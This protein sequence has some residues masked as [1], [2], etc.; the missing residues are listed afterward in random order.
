MSFSRY[1]SHRLIALLVM[2][3]VVG[4]GGQSAP[5]P[6]VKHAAHLQK[7]HARHLISQTESTPALQKQMHAKLRQANG[8]NGLT[9]SMQANGRVVDVF[10]EWIVESAGSSTPV[11]TRITYVVYSFMSETVLATGKVDPQ[12]S[13]NTEV[14][15][16]TGD[17][18]CPIVT[19][20]IF[21]TSAT[22][23]RTLNYDRTQGIAKLDFLV[24]TVD[25]S[26]GEI[27]FVD[28]KPTNAICS[29]NDVE[30][31]YGAG[32]YNPVLK[33]A[34]GTPFTRLKMVDVNE[35]TGVGGNYR[36]YPGVKYMFGWG[37]Q[38]C[39][40][41]L[42]D[43][44]TGNCVRGP[45]THAGLVGAKLTD[46][47][48][49]SG[50]I[51][52]G[53]IDPADTPY[54]SNFSILDFD[55]VISINAG[56]DPVNG[57]SFQYAVS[58][59]SGASNI[60][61][62][63]ILTS[64]GG[65]NPLGQQGYFDKSRWVS[66]GPAAN[67][68]PLGLLDSRSVVLMP[69]SGSVG[70]TYNFMQPML[71]WT[72]SLLL[73]D[74]YINSPG[75]LCR[76]PSGGGGCTALGES[77]MQVGFPPVG[78]VPGANYFAA[79]YSG[80]TLFAPLKSFLSTGE[81][82]E[83]QRKYIFYAD[84]RELHPGKMGQP[85][86]AMFRPR[87]L[88]DTAS[89]PLAM[90]LPG[91]LVGDFVVPINS[92]QPQPTV[93]VGQMEF[94]AAKDYLGD[95][96]AYQIIRFDDTGSV[97]PSDTSG[98]Q[99]VAGGVMFCTSKL[100]PPGSPVAISGA[101][102][103]VPRPNAVGAEGFSIASALDI[104]PSATYQASPSKVGYTISPSG[105]VYL[106]YIAQSGAIATINATD[107]SQKWSAGNSAWDVLSTGRLAACLQ[108]LKAQPSPPS[109]NLGFWSR[110]GA[111]F[112]DV[113]FYTIVDAA[114]EAV[115]GPFGP[116]LAD[117]V[118]GMG[119]SYLEDQANATGDQSYLQIYGGSVLTTTCKVD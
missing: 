83:Q 89:P 17:T 46:G 79:P 65:E 81:A 45:T 34:T 25:G 94:F 61:G 110:L 62:T 113:V 72:P 9:S 64:N 69:S 47:V 14:W 57:A 90:T 103:V 26:L 11:E 104:L 24:G 54:T 51:L 108:T 84:T 20:L 76:Y 12:G 35:L 48:A 58:M 18:W 116:V 40:A 75:Y 82:Q 36:V 67:T 88:T 7:L 101:A 37:P 44:Q 115:M 63:K 56:G 33:S 49:A 41:S 117:M 87:L 13:V 30:P 8:L 93:T 32:F 107:P 39:P 55:A 68:P 74:L 52:A 78:I 118:L 4:C 102:C 109:K 5:S 59:A 10:D 100:A 71:L 70:M 42:V 28:K 27:A 43:G 29:S 6:A 86:A 15:R 38:A 99:L 23:R 77:F 50:S 1:V 105:I 106:N 119:E 98:R 95:S 85:Y 80:N 2:L 92:S 66:F 3:T 91:G 111:V 22:L 112:E 21:S 114:A 60:L 73:Q 96:R 19:G 53:V 31:M 97:A 16:R